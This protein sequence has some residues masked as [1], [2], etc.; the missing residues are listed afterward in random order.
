V[1]ESGVGTGRASTLARSQR[2]ECE[3]HL[4]RQKGAWGCLRRPGLTLSRP[5]PVAPGAMQQVT[6]GAGC[7]GYVAK[8][9]S[10]TRATCHGAP[11]LV[12]RTS[13]RVSK[14]VAL[15]LV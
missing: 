4:T 2:Q 1:H 5:E 13:K 7:D 10:P 15:N 12:R 9:F 14:A 3:G 6:R 11:V 8:S